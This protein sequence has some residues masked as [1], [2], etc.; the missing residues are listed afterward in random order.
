MGTFGDTNAGAVD[1]NTA[2]T[3]I[4]A[5]NLTFISG[6]TI[7]LDKSGDTSPTALTDSGSSNTTLT[8]QAGTDIITAGAITNSGTG[9]LNVLMDAD[10]ANGGGAITIGGNITT[11]DGNI[12]MGG[13]NGAITAGTLNAD[14]TINAAATGFAVGDAANHYG[15]LVAS[16]ATVNAGA[17]NIIMNGQGYGNL[18]S[19][20][21]IYITGGTVEASGNINVSGTGV[22]DSG[23]GSAAKI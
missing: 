19:A 4:T 5:K 21:G 14:G 16:G 6:G 18:S 3:N 13:G 22:G 7:Y 11:L 15:I 17:G 10:Y 1:I 2:A 8:M 12:T 23:G 9:K 20:N